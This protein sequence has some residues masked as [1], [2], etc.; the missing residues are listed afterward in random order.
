MP[1]GSVGHVE[2]TVHID[3]VHRSPVRHAYIVEDDVALDA[4][5]FD[6]AIDLAE[7]VDGGTVRRFDAFRVADAVIVGDGGVADPRVQRD[8]PAWRCLQWIR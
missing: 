8:I 5:I 3:P 1:R 6:D 4:R 2:S 7:C